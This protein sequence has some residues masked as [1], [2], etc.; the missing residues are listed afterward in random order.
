VLLLLEVVK[1]VVVLA[2][3]EVVVVKGDV[4]AVLVVSVC[5]IG[6]IQSVIFL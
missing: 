1:E 2:K 4:E 3:V 6:C 5:N